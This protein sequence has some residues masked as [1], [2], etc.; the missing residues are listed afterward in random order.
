MG[1]SLAAGMVGWLL[2][3]FQYEADK[4][5]SPFT[6]NGIALMLTVIPGISTS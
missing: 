3:Y 4:V 6:L 2:V 1:M 5:Q